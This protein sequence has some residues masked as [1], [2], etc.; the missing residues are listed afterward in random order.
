MRLIFEINL[1][2][3]GLKYVSSVSIMLTVSFLMRYL[4]LS[5]KQK[6][7]INSEGV[8][9][10]KMNKAYGTIGFIEIGITTLIGIL[11]SLDTV[12]SLV[13]FFILYGVVILFLSL[14]V[15]LVLVSRNMKIEVDNNKI[16]Y[17]GFTG[18]SKEILWNEIKKT[19]F[20]KSTLELS[21]IAAST[22]VKIYMYTIGFSS[23]I[24][25]MKEKVDYL[26]YKD[27]LV[28]IELVDKR[29]N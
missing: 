25:F 16:K 22:K 28:A 18:K 27:A 7:M 6:P 12:K 14:G 23:F 1:E 24:D 4:A 17:Y 19:K 10:L 13:D 29:F 21:L 15:T 11:G 3:A 26:I 8:M 9:I 2:V 20:N 5:S